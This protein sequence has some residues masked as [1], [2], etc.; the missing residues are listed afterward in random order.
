[1]PKHSFCYLILF[2]LYSTQFSMGLNGADSYYTADD[3]SQAIYHGDIN[4]VKTVLAACPKLVNEPHR[5]QLPLVRSVR[6]SAHPNHLEILVYLLN[7]GANIN[8]SACPPYLDATAMFYAVNEPDNRIIQIL[9]EHGADPNGRDSRGSTPLLAAMTNSSIEKIKLLISS[10]GDIHVRDNNGNTAL[11]YA[12]AVDCNYFG[13]PPNRTRLSFALDAGC[14]INAVNINDETALHVAAGHL[15]EEGID[16][17]LQHGASTWMRDND[18]RTA[19]VA[20]IQCFEDYDRRQVMEQFTQIIQPDTAFQD[21]INNDYGYDLEQYER[22][23]KHLYAAQEH[24]F[25][26]ALWLAYLIIL[27][28]LH[29]SLSKF[30]A[31]APTKSSNTLSLAAEIPATTN[32]PSPGR[33]QAVEILARVREIENHRDNDRVHLAPPAVAWLL[34]MVI[35]AVDPILNLYPST[36]WIKPMALSVS[37]ALASGMSFMPYRQ[38]RM[39][40]ALLGALTVAA[41]GFWI[42]FDLYFLLFQAGFIEIGLLLS[43]LSLMALTALYYFMRIF[44]TERILRKLQP[45][46]PSKLPHD[47]AEFDVPAGW[48]E[49]TRKK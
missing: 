17:L 23:V 49:S 37:F 15:D 16:F 13:P 5:N 25:N 22:V 32:T 2:L 46:P 20:A 29:F 12:E 43:S 1:M 40:G 44:R 27:A 28:A 30:R 8:Q 26:M 6:S 3:L 35:Y 18:G 45:P 39:F 10:G 24:P 14:D 38:L 47:P 41:A 42:F 19:L 7:H 21:R 36:L 11:H 34:C 33:E 9:L 48:D 31:G 4:Q